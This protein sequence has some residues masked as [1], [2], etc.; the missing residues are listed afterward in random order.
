M[1]ARAAGGRRRPVVVTIDGP[2]GAGKSTAARRLADR[3]GF[4]YVNSGAIYRAVA[5]RVRGGAPLEA[6]LRTLRVEFARGDG[7]QRVRVDGVDVTEALYT[8]EVSELAA[9]LSTRPEVRAYADALQRACAARGSVVVEGRDAGTVVFPGADCKFFLDASL[10]ARARRRLAE[11]RAAGEAAD[12]AAIR[13]AI[14]ARDEADANRPVAPLTRS[15]DATWIDSSDLTVD[16][17]VE[18]M[19][20][21]VERTCSTRC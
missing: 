3:L 17:V 15:A 19:A 13:D 4:A 10:E 11:R 18:L 16:E 14:R 21:E 20:K 5:W 1:I 9:A 8:P 6:V 12:L 2:A 7:G